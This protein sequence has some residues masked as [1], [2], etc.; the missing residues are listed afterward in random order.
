MREILFRIPHYNASNN[1]FSHFSVWGAIDH[2]GECVTNHSCFSS[3]S[4]NNSTYK[5]WHEQFTGITD[6]N[7]VK[8]FEGDIVK[9]ITQSGLIENEGI[10]VI[11]N[12]RWACFM[13]QAANDIS[14]YAI[15]YY[16]FEVTGNIHDKTN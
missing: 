14:W 1:E 9:V 10:T 6:K 5:K 7:G 16:R 8:I 3:P 11:Y 13:L 2:R 12:Q 15:R 4:S